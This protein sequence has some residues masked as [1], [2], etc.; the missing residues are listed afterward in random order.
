MH[1]AW[2]ILVASAFGHVGWVDEPLYSYRQHG[3]NVLGETAVGAKHF[4]ARA[5]EGV[6]AFRIRLAA[7]GTRDVCRS[8]DSP[9]EVC[10]AE[11]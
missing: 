3:N 2:M 9:Q 11:R 5:R 6:V 7:E 1:D 10:V 4:L 8:W